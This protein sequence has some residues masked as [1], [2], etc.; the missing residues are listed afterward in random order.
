[1]GIERIHKSH[2][3]PVPYP[4]MHHSEQNCAIRCEIGQHKATGSIG[5]AEFSTARMYKHLSGG[6]KSI[7][8]PLIIIWIENHIH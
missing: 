2:N 1:M 3:A 5:H 4:K 8:G 7:W 6:R